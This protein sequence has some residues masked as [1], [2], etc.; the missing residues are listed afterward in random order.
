MTVDGDLTADNIV[1]AGNVDGRDV[2]T[3][4]TKLDLIGAGADVVGPASSTDNEIARQH[5]TTGKILQTYTSNPPTISDTGDVNIDGDLDVENIV[6]SGNVDGVD[7]S[8][9]ATT[10]AANATLG[11]VIV[12]TASD[13]DVDGDGKLTLGSHATN[14]ENGGSDEI[15]IINLVTEAGF[16]QIPTAAGW[17][18][19]VANGGTVTQ[20]PTRMLVQSSATANGRAMAIAF[21]FGFQP[22]AL[23]NIWNWDKKTILKFDLTAANTVALSDRYFQFFTE[24]TFDWGDMDNKG[25]GVYSD[26][27]TLYGESYGTERGVVDLNHTL[28]HYFGD[29]I[30]I[31]HDPTV[32]SI[33]WYINGSLAGTQSTAAKIP[34][35]VASTSPG[36]QLS[37]DNGGTETDA[38]LQIMNAYLWREA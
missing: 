37:V 36:L 20:Q 14:H 17:S 24:A 16:V 8:T 29:R 23:F 3:D 30:V 22:G 11:H 26:N 7:V 18:E 1:T 9:H 6:V 12:E 13:I 27:L 19:S 4:G 5:S 32:P 2:S 21:M 38:T 10:K 25:M 34:S 31:V 35:G 15:D 28:T 33:K